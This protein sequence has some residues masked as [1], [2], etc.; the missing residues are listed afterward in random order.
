MR[1][2]SILTYAVAKH[3]N[4]YAVVLT[5][6]VRHIFRTFTT[7]TILGVF[8]NRKEAEEFSADYTDNIQDY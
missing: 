3:Q 1:Y 7:Q 6:K 2:V 5:E 4:A 8:P